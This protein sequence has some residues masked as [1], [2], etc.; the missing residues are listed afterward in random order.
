MNSRLL[1]ANEDVMQGLLVVVE[2]IVGRH[3]GASRITEEHIYAFVLKA[4]HQC[5]STAYLCIHNLT[6]PLSA[7]LTLLA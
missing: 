1:V 4:S 6:P 3:D 5:L 2:G 7:L